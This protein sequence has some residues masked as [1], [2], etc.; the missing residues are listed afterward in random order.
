[1]NKKDKLQNMIDKL[2]DMY[3]DLKEY[4][5]SDTLSALDSLISNIELD[6]RELEN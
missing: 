6:L 3:L 5:P 2:E 4:A 1:M